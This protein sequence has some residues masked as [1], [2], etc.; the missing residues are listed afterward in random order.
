[1][2][3][4]VVMKYYTMES[5]LQC[6]LCKYRKNPKECIKAIHS[7]NWNCPTLSNIWYGKLIKW[8]PFNIIDFIQWKIYFKR[9]EKEY[10]GY[11]ENLE[12]DE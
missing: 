10:E 9:A 7:N 5:D 4:G 11:Y 3:K 12:D 1:M 2:V 6:I 8:F